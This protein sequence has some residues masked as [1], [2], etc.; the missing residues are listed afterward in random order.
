MNI[1]GTGLP[2]LWLLQYL[3]L[4]AQKCKYFFR[5]QFFALNKSEQKGH[6]NPRFAF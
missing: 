6:V 1:T 4:E 2:V 3:L 5:F